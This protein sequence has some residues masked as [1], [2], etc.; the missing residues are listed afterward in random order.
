MRNVAYA[1]MGERVYQILDDSGG[2][3]VTAVKKIANMKHPNTNTKIG[4]K[5]ALDAYA[6]YLED[7]IPY[8][9]EEYRYNIDKFHAKI[10]KKLIA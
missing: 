4:K 8:D 5:L 3:H 9:E 2:K 1:K 6:R 7:T 10:K